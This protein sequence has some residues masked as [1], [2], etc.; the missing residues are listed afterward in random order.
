MLLPYSGICYYCYFP[1]QTFITIEADLCTRTFLPQS[2]FLIHPVCPELCDLTNRFPSLTS[3]S[4]MR[5]CHGN[6]L[7]I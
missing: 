4:G 2:H 5:Q 1:M 6:S 7:T 3:L